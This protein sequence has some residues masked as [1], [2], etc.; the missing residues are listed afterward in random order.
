MIIQISGYPVIIDDEDYDRI[1]KLTWHINKRNETKSCFY[2]QS[3]LP[4][5]RKY[6]VLHRFILKVTDSDMIVDH[7]NGDGCDN[8]KS[9]LR[10]CTQN[11]NTKNCRTYYRNTSGYKGVSFDK[12]AH[13]YRAQIQVNKKKITIGFYDDPKEAYNAY[14]EASKKY[15]GEFGRVE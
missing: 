4:V 12:C 11:D 3:R 2:F 10:L 13:K 5:T 9:N 7:I 6:I 15:H 14:C 8:R 1:S